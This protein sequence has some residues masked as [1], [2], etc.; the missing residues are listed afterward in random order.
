MGVVPPLPPAWPYQRLVYTTSDWNA[1]QMAED[2][3]AIWP[4]CEYCAR[5]QQ[6]PDD[7]RCLGCGATLKMRTR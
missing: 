7:G 3:R 2:A 1:T 6:M 5:V 4:K